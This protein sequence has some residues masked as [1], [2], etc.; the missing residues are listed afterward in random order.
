MSNRTSTLVRLDVE[1][2]EALKQISKIEDRSTNK[3][4]E[5]ILKDYIR[6]NYPELNNTKP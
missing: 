5:F 2:L 1:L 3:Q 4:I 6:T